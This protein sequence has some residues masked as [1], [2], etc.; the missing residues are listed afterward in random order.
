MGAEVPVKVPGDT[1]TAIEY[2]AGTS[3]EVQNITRNAQLSL[4]PNDYNQSTTSISRIGSNSMMW[5]FLEISTENSYILKK[6]TGLTN[7]NPQKYFN[8]MVV[9]FTLTDANFVNTSSIIQLT[10]VDDSDVPFEG[11]PIFVDANTVEIGDIA[12]G[13]THKFV[14]LGNSGSY[15]WRYLKQGG[16]DVFARN[17]INNVIAAGVTSY[18]GVINVNTGNPTF[19]T[20]TLNAISVA[21]VTPSGQPEIVIQL[22]T[23]KS[24]SF[25][26]TVTPAYTE[27]GTTGVFYE[28][29]FT[30]QYRSD[31]STPT[32]DVFDIYAVNSSQTPE[33]G[34]SNF[35]FLIF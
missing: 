26:L 27:I 35:N 30:V 31:L 5:F 2:T 28:S 21:D 17:E 3:Q 25:A 15:I 9:E 11:S 20:G 7:T 6:I 12:E 23:Q 29:Y 32:Q 16:V 14:L 4:N 33:S 1:Y 10:L 18:G 8:G 19:A 34:V 13:V 22:T 24:K